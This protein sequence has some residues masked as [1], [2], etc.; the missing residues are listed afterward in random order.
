MPMKISDFEKTVIGKIKEKFEVKEFSGHH[1][2]YEIYHKGRRVARTHRSHGSRG[3]DFSDDILQKIKRQ[4]YLDN[5][6]QLYDLKNC[7]MK[8]ED[9]F[10]LLKQKNVISD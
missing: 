6:G 1:I 3:K 5:V 4:L 9:Y 10:N 8:S 7:P 2:F